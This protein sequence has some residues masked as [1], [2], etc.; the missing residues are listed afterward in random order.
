MLG[1]GNAVQCHAGTLCCRELRRGKVLST[2]LLSREMLPILRRI[3][4]GIQVVSTPFTIYI[5]LDSKRKWLDADYLNYHLIV[6]KGSGSTLKEVARRR[7]VRPHV[8]HP[9]H[10]LL[11]SNHA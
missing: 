7:N 6:K 10:R 1:G 2:E 3:K 11:K 9:A 5:S 4:S 8:I